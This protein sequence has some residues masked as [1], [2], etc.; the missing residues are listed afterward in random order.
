MNSEPEEQLDR[1]RSEIR[2]DAEAA[3]RQAP[4][5]PRT[6]VVAEAVRDTASSVERVTI[7]ELASLS[8][9]TFVDQ[10]FRRILKREP[11]PVGFERQMAA[12]A[13]GANKIEVL[14]DLRFSAEGRRTGVDVPGLAPRYFL[15]KL[16]RMP[17]LGAFVRWLI[18]L[19][20]LAHILRHQRATEASLAVQFGET[21]AALHAG[22]QRDAE[23]REMLNASAVAMTELS[24]RLNGLSERIGQVESYAR[25]LDAAVTELRGL[26]LAMN[27]W[28]VQLRQ[29]VEAI[30]SAESERRA[31]EDETSAALIERMRGLD[32]DRLRRMDAWTSELARRL[33]GKGRV[34][35]VCG[36]PKWFDALALDG[37]NVSAI[38]TN[39]VLHRRARDD[40]RDVTLGDPVAL[41]AR[42]ADA[43]LDAVSFAA[44]RVL[45]DVTVVEIVREAL[46]IV[47]PRGVLL[48]DLGRSATHFDAAL[49]R[50]ALAVGFADPAAIDAFSGKALVFVRP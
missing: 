27:H 8:G 40:G 29:C 21:R 22:E 28:T 46:R 31:R 24:E 6:V 15:G 10:A 3:R 32:T 1:V 16:G 48:I 20:S 9:P 2:A 38:E 14:G 33:S 42:I 30:E 41:M 37:W 23:H 50:V 11:D 45:D 4:L 26:T 19:A 44:D 25:G 12:L 43:S 17:I 36:D 47:K 18:A 13:A 5:P 7:A 34:L 35:D 39:S 49:S